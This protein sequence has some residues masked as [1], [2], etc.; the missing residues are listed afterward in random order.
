M[1][2]AAAGVCNGQAGGERAGMKFL[3]ALVLGAAGLASGAAA[4]FSPAWFNDAW[5]F[6]GKAEFLIYEGTQGRYGSQH[7]AEVIHILVR[8]NFAPEQPVKADDWNRPGA[9]PVLKLNQILRIPTGL[10]VYQQMHSSFWTPEN[11]RLVKWSLTSNDSCGNT[12]KVATRPREVGKDAWGYSYETYWEGQMRG[13]TEVKDAADGVHYDELPARV[14]SLD[15]SKESGGFEFPLAPTA[16]TSKRGSLEFKPARISWKRGGEGRFDVEV[17]HAQGAD[18]FSVD[19]KPP[20]L[21]REWRAW[22]GSFLTLRHALKCA[23]WELH[24]P[25]DR[26]RA[27]ADP[28]LRIP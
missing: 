13:T 23:Y 26:E 9:Y 6:D 10:Y 25:G 5:W 11:A 27:L 4:Q 22:D 12:F 17:K 21:V 16:I 2:P 7:P 19:A 20:H 18:R 1:L 24:N 8:E 28:A 15:F 14:R 3:A